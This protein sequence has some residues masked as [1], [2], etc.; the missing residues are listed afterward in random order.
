MGRSSS[1]RIAA[2]TA[3]SARRVRQLLGGS[4]SA[5]SL[6]YVG[7][8]VKPWCPGN[9]SSI[10]NGRAAICGYNSTARR[11]RGCGDVELLAPEVGVGVDLDQ[12]KRQGSLDLG[13]QALH[14]LEFL[15]GRDDVL[16]GRRPAGPA[17]RRPGRRRAIARPRP[18]SSS[19][20]AKVPG[21][22]SPSMARW[23][24]VREVE[25]PSAPASIAS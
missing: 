12:R 9:P 23:A 15:L 6:R 14:P 13:A 7:R 24:I 17:R 8:W 16:A 20:A 2:F 5:L 4:S 25:K 19:S 21:T 18:N 10:P 3:G 1:D 22:G 11:V